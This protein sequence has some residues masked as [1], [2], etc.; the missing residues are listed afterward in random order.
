[1]PYHG[2]Q[3]FFLPAFGAKRLVNDPDRDRNPA[4]PGGWASRLRRHLAWVIALKIALI[5]L[6]FA[7]FFSPD[8]RPQID[9]SGVSDR[10]RL[11]R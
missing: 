6:L 7:L 8:H 4:R 3:R 1:M 5:A 9:P 10:L 11:D 2:G